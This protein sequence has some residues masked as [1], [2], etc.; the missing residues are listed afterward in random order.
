M[1]A[2]FGDQLVHPRSVGD[3]A[4]VEEEILSRQMIIVVQMIDP[5]TVERAG[6]PHKSVDLITLVQ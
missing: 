5:G 3:I 6:S 2:K 4:V 1:R